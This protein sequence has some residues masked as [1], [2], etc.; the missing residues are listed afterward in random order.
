MVAAAANMRNI[1]TKR[2]RRRV[3]Y[4]VYD[5]SAIESMRFAARMDSDEKIAAVWKERKLSES[6][7]FCIRIFIISHSHELMSEKKRK[8]LLQS[9]IASEI[10]RF[11]R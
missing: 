1:S 5:S 7:D 9:R 3:F 11:D 2:R 8:D 10:P 4:V 6:W